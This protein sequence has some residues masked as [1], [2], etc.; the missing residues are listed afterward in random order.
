MQGLDREKYRTT[1]SD[2]A[3]MKNNSSS[4]YWFVFMFVAGIFVWAISFDLYRDI[5]A[6]TWPTT[7]GILSTAYRASAFT[8]DYQNDGTR[9]TPIFEPSRTRG[10]TFSFEV[11]GLRYE[12]SNK[13]FGITLSNDFEVINTGDK[14]KS[15]VKVY[16]NP[17]DPSE[18]VLIPG[19]KIINI[20]LLVL[21]I[22]A[23]LWTIRR[24]RHQ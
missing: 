16:F 3:S 10:Q 19:P 24:V 11:N 20:G 17:N 21:S 4:S 8:Q 9:D 5:K 15:V 6:E 18:S 7:P 22:I 2:A 1:S 14:N 23:M 13:S 12:S